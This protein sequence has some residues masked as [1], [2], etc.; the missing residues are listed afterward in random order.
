MVF[1]LG[2]SKKP[3]MPC[4]EKRARKMLEAKRAVVHKLYP[5]TIRLKD[6]VD[7]DMQ[8]VC[9]KL[10]P[11]SKQ[12]GIAV[13]RDEEAVDPG[14]GELRRIAHVMMLLQLNHRGVAISDAL[15]SRASMR[16]TRRVRKTR[17]RKARFSNRPK[18]KGWLAAG[19]A[20]VH[21]L[22]AHA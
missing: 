19:Q 17:Y 9:I 8:P 2:K 18:A 1:V 15:K 13:V 10:D 12:T 6:R 20:S 14:T 22:S 3:L 16:R 21:G 11:G 4:S 5:F 7:G